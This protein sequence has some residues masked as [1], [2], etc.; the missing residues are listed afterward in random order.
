MA[1]VLMMKDLGSSK[2]WWVLLALPLLWLGCG[3]KLTKD[4]NEDITDVKATN[5]QPL[6]E[7]LALTEV[8]TD[9]N[10]VIVENGKNAWP[11]I[12]YPEAPPRTRACAE[13]LADYIA[14]ISGVRPNVSYRTPATIPAKAIWIG[15]Q[16][17]VQQLFAD[18]DLD[19]H[20]PE[21]IIIRSTSDHVLIAGRDRWVE[22]GMI[23]QGR[24]KSIENVQ[25]EYGTC[26]AI[27]TFIQDYLNVRWL[28]PGIL[29]EDYS[30]TTTIALPH[31]RYRYYPQLRARDGVFRFTELGE[32][33]SSQE[34][35]DW[36]R[37]QRLQ[38]SSLLV[39]GGHGFT[40][41]WETYHKEHPEFFALLPNGKREPIDDPQKVK[42]CVSTPGVWRQWL[43]E[44]KITLKEN[45]S[46]QVFNA[47]PNDGWNR[48]QCTC[49]H[50]QAWDEVPMTAA[51]PN[52]ADRHTRF[53]NELAKLLVEAYP[54]KDYYVQLH[55][56][57]Y[58]KKAPIKAKV[59]ERV[60]ISAVH[61]L[62]IRNKALH[63]EY[64]EEKA[65]FVAWNKAAKHV[66]WRLNLP[67]YA[68]H[69]VGMPEIAPRQSYDDL[70]FAVRQ[71]I[72]GIWI[73]TYWG[74]WSTQLPQYYLMSQLVWNPN[75]SYEVIMDDF[76]RRAYGPAN[77]IMAAYW[78]ELEKMREKLLAAYPDQ[79]SFFLMHE[80][81]DEAWISGARR[82]LERALIMAQGQDI[83][84]KRIQYHQTGLDI[85]ADMLE[86]RR[87]QS[88]VQNSRNPDGIKNEIDAKW[89]KAQQK[90]EKAPL[91]A[92]NKIYLFRD[93]MNGK[94]NSMHYDFQPKK[95][96]ERFLKR[97]QN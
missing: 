38:Y 74:H 49:R 82:M 84:S 12:V 77:E 5:L 91:D 94:T 85:V 76:Y 67:G 69:G 87:L 33:R 97:N 44:V 46:Q 34:E 47:S 79:F 81:Y 21:E 35:Q 50:C 13:E 58:A 36:A 42:L 31:I 1:E 66:V 96:V 20:A 26:N 59:H 17:P 70:Q 65:E 83:F 95:K 73:D 55:A 2:W 64:E 10:I 61:Q 54:D 32:K 52:M 8:G 9:K 3:K 14:K 22:G 7:T 39:E 89:K 4:T 78:T 63:P 93:S 80:V 24:R 15:V 90:V 56:Y 48:G 57:G 29:W 72:E 92:F 23:A 40:H 43:E 71:G 88:Q 75:Q 41:W 30:K 51:E 25:Q 60:I 68:G 18:E 11:I 86:L 16:P 27:Y 19:F 6:E 45:P 37:R 53:A 62:F 28:G